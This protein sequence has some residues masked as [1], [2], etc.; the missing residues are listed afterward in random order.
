MVE[1][2]DIKFPTSNVRAGYIPKESYFSPEFARLEEEQLWPRVWQIACRL[3]E[4]PNRGDFI[5]YD[6]VDDSITVVRVDEEN[7]RAFHNVCPHRGRRLTEGCGHATQFACRFHGWRFGIDGKNTR[8]VDPQDWGDLLEPGAADLKPVQAATWGGAVWINMDMEAE[9]LLTFL[10][11]MRDY[12]DKFEFEKLRYRWYKTVILQ[13]N[14]KIALEFFNEFYHVQ[15]AHPQLLTFTDDYS[16]SGG[17]GRH[18]MMWF[19]AEGAVPFR[20]SPRLNPKEEPD[21]RK[22]ILD[23]VENYNRDLQAMVTPRNYEAT[24][25]LRTEVSADASPTEVLT[26]WVQFQME[27]AEADGSGW[28]ADLTPEDIEKSGLDWHV[29]PNTIFLH[30]T[31][32]GVLW[33]RVRPNGHD[34]ESCIFDVW[35]LQRYGEGKAPP[36]EREFYADWRDTEWPKIYEQDFVNIPEVQKGMRSRVFS[37]SRP[38]PVQEAAILNFHQQLREFMGQGPIVDDDMQIRQAAE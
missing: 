19:D 4:I 29:F 15:Q 33:Y 3:E 10:E 31:V 25:R 6:I 14:W 36:L 37:A 21:Y 24:Q 23:F 16:K 26:K 2:A 12:I 27:A 22:F 8:I 17:F 35:S 30:G 11:P 7:V 1:A 13:S 9:P 32:D 18:G 5:T 28:P 34:P 38:N 20:R